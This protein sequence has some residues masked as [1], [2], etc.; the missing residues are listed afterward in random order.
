M[1]EDR[2]QRTVFYRGGRKERRDFFNHGLARILTD[3]V[4]R[5]GI[6]DKVFALNVVYA[7]DLYL[8]CRA[9]SSPTPKAFAG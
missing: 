3:L 1:T 5:R 6:L 7:Q 9:T 4:S 8:V 2:R